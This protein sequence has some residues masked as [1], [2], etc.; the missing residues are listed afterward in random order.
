MKEESTC[1]ETRSLLERAVVSGTPLPE[2]AIEHLKTCRECG[3][4]VDSMRVLL[5]EEPTEK[6]GHGH[7]GEE[8]T[9][10]GD[11]VEE[12]ILAAR[13]QTM[14]SHRHR[15][16][17]RIVA[18]SAVTAILAAL[19]ARGT[20]PELAARLAGAVFLFSLPVYSAILGLFTFL[21]RRPH[22]RL[23]KRLKPGYMLSGVC[24][25]LSERLGVSPTLVR[26]LF[27]ALVLFGKGAGFWL[28]VILDLLMPVHPEDRSRLRRFRIARWW[29]RVWSRSE[30]P[31]GT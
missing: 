9:R 5:S 8:D 24:L 25:G 7:I 3:S 16:L 4:I 13:R 1:R 26:L 27:V 6:G 11:N 10:G 22:S 19:M 17:A 29:G 2:G 28:Y 14:R 31:S 30:L 15:N 18:A 12:T 23:Y 21:R 20:G